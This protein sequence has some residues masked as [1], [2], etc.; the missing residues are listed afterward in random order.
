MSESQRVE[1]NWE[2]PSLEE[3]PKISAMHVGAMEQSDDDMV[4]VQ[5]GMHHVLLRLT[6]RKSGKEHKV[7][8][9][10]WRDAAGNRIV[11]ASFAGA[12]QHPAWFLNLQDREANPEVLVRVQGGRQFW[13]RP[14]ILD[15]DEYQRTW[16]AL[17]ADRAW[18]RDYQAKTERRI[19]LVRLPET[20]PA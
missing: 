12:D 19:P 2:T 5:A 7:A 10:F 6:G 9:P 20:R 4:W 11:V 13:S 18:Y 17:T 15:G 8:L 14:D 16:D 1:Q 3:I